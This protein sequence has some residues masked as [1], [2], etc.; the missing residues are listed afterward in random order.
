MIY[1]MLGFQGVPKHFNPT[2]SIMAETFFGKS[3][4]R[5]PTRIGF[6]LDDLMNVDLKIQPTDFLHEHLELLRDGTV[7]VFRMSKSST[8]AMLLDYSTNKIA[9]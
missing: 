1:M 8:L 7:K 2:F 4:S 5:S 6:S 3:E 9:E